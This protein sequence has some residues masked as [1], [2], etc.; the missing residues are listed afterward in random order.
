MLSQTVLLKGVND[1]AGVL[2][3]QLALSARLVANIP[4]LEP[5]VEIIASQ[6]KHFDGTG[7]P[8]D[9]R[10]GQ[11]IPLGARIIKAVAD[12]QRL[13]DEGREPVEIMAALQKRR[14]IYDPAVLD[15][16]LPWLQVQFGNASS[17]HEY[18]RAARQAVD[19]ARQQVAAAVGHQ[20]PFTLLVELADDPGAHVFPPVV[21]LFLQLVFEELALFLHHQDFL[22][23]LGEAA[24]A[25]GLQGPD[26]AHLEEADADLGGQGV[27]ERD[28]VEGWLGMR[29]GRDAADVAAG[30]RGG[31]G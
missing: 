4:R 17:R 18:G 12:Y 5:V 24:H 22:Q 14:G 29:V 7:L 19:R 31:D 15:A 11:D 20:G 9:G 2:A 30:R 25:V 1:D 10:A 16:M 21:E 6:E 28:L 26:H 3:E 27:V 8:R 23:P 13:L